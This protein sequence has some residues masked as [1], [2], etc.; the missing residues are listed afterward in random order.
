M[1]Q[2]DMTA[3]VKPGTTERIGVIQDFVD[4][5]LT[6][7]LGDLVDE[8]AS[9]PQVKT[10]CGYACSDHA[11]WSKIGVPSS[12][13]IE[14]SFEDSNKNIHSSRGHDRGGGLFVLAQY[15]HGY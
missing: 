10:K 5:Q 3:Y 1:L 7:L 13:A 11:S 9:I 12:F 4:P 8:Y 6:A 14:S 15:V 2:M